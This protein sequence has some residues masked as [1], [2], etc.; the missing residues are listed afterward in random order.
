MNEDSIIRYID[1]IN[2]KIEL[3]ECKLEELYER[4]AELQE[5]CSHNVVFRIK[6]NGLYGRNSI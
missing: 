2:E 6:D 4:K 5:L 3:L 1:V